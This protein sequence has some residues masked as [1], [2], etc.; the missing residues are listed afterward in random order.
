M[1]FNTSSTPGMSLYTI[2]LL[3]TYIE[4][5]SF[6]GEFLPFYHFFSFLVKMKEFIAKKKAIK[7]ILKTEYFITHSLFRKKLPKIVT[8]AYDMKRH[9]RFLLLS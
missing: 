1:V 6:G 5:E 9:F 7:I 3:C 2:E 8:T 4:L